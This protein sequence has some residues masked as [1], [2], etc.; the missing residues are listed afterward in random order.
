MDD[1]GVSGCGPYILRHTHATLLFEAGLDLAQVADRLG[2]ASAEFT[3][4]T[5]VHVLPHRQ[6]DVLDVLEAMA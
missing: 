1:L 5:Y 2:H 3:A 4:D 6:R